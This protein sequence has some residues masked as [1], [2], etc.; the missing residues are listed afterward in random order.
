MNSINFIYEYPSDYH[1]NGVIKVEIGFCEKV[2]FPLTFQVIGLIDNKIYWETKNM[3]EGHWSLYPDACNKKAIIIDSN[4]Y[5]IKEWIWNQE[6]HGDKIHKDFY[7]WCLI[8]KGANGIAIGTH[9]GSSGEWVSPIR[10]KLINGYLVEPSDMQFGYLCNNYINY[11]NVSLIQKLITKNGGYVDFFEGGEGYTNSV[12]K[13][14][15]LVY[16]NND[17]NLVHKVQ[18]ESITINQLIIDC[19]LKD[20]INWLHIDVEGIDDELIMSLDDKLIK[21]PDI[22]IYEDLNLSSERKNELNK[23]L[24]SKNY[25][26]YHSGFNTMAK[27]QPIKVSV[28]IPCYNYSKYIEQCLMSVMLQNIDFNIEVLIGDDNSSDCSFDIIKRFC[29]FI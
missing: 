3:V 19:G 8:N 26:F 7:E 29:E 20:N 25:K 2:N 9:D 4:N 6:E 24:E 11:S 10:E 28:I 14:F 1:S 16:N 27:K 15:V 13:E 17:E 18:K 5:I 12:N 21:L 22:I 23:W